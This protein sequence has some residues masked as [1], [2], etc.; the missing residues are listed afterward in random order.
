MLTIRKEQIEIFQQCTLR[1]FENNMIRHLHE[2]SP[3]QSEI[4]G[5]DGLRKVVRLGVKQAES[6]GFTHSGP[7]QFYLELMFMFGSYFDTDCQ[8]SWALDILTDD[9][10]DDQTERADILYEKFIDYLDK[11]AGSDWGNARTSLGRISKQS[12]KDLEENKDDLEA[13]ILARFHLDFPQKCR[14]LGDR[15]LLQIIQL[16]AESA[17]KFS[18]SSNSGVKFFA[19][20]MFMLGRGFSVDPLYPWCEGTLNDEAI[21]DPRERI[22]QLHSKGTAYLTKVLAA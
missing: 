17:E 20:F 11:V 7:V 2:F 15:V 3:A 22:K 14:Y 18:V 21:T 16:A 8:Y 19:Q 1:N 4:L 9:E 12:F 6:Y 10:I 13:D 5:Q